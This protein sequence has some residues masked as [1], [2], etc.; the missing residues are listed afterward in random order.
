LGTSFN[1]SAYPAENY[2]EIVL[3]NGKVE[4]LDNIGEKKTTMF[5]SE[6]LIYKNGNIAKSFTDPAKYNAWT[7]GKLVFR[8]DPMDEVSRRIE[9]WYNVKVVL[10]DKELER[11]SFR[12]TFEDD[13]LKDVLRFLSMTSPIRYQIIPRKAMPDGTYEKEEVTIYLKKL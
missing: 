9:R 6:R 7:E 1:I 8:G 10:A 11:Y 2:V 3:Q 5:P 13:N 4:F 12:A